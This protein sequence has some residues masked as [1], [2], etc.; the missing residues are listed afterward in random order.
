[1][2]LVE[3]WKASRQDWCSQPDGG[4]GGHGNAAKDAKDAPS[5]TC[6]PFAQKHKE[7]VKDVFCEARNIVVDFSKVR[8]EP[9]KTKIRN[10]DNYL[11]FS[12]GALQSACKKTSN[13]KAAGLMKHQ[14]RLFGTFEDG[15]EDGAKA[16]PAVEVAHTTYFLQ[17]DEDCENAFH[18]TADFMN[19]FL[20]MN[21]LEIKPQDQQVV[22][23]ASCPAARLF[24][25]PSSTY[26]HPTPNPPSIGD[27]LRPTHRRTLPRAHQESLLPRL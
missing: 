23:S 20:V 4:D 16:V 5:I 19:M 11:H 21:A 13:Y 24:H 9:Q 6:Y 12:Q 27:T 17:R 10:G 25:L 14:Q 1:M 7:R 26:L 15:I 22:H 8:G 18:S 2:T 3:Q